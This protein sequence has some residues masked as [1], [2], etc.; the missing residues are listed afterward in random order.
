LHS[1]EQ[2]DLTVFYEDYPYNRRRLDDFTRHVFAHYIRRLQKHGLRPTHCVLDYGCSGGLLLDYLR[3]RGFRTCTGYD[4]YSLTFSD[5]TTLSHQYDAVICQDVIE[6]VEDSRRLMRMLS[7][8]IRPGGLLCIGTPRAEGIDLHNPNRAIHSLHQ[9]YHLHILSEKA[10]KDI[11]TDEGLVLEKLYRRHS[12]DTWFP[13]VNW[14][15]LRAYLGMIDDTLDGGFDRPRVDLVVKSPRLWF[16]GL[17]GYLLG[18]H[19]EMIAV[20]RK[21]TSAE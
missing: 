1:C 5:P 3:E 12:C 9:P 10:L 17:F 19:S 13:F 8:A 4:P 2:Q 21:P 6:H 11:A 14:P 20:F 7:R 16:L 18:C 15:F